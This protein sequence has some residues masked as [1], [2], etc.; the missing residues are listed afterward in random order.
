MTLDLFS[1]EPVPA[2]AAAPA[3][4]RESFMMQPTGEPN[5][6]RYRGVL[7]ACDMKL[8]GL[9]GHW[10]TLEPIGGQA[11]ATSDLRVELCREIDKQLQQPER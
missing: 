9:V 10:S 4:S 1:D 6:W 5:R 7:V 3:P 2:P 8:K 11:I